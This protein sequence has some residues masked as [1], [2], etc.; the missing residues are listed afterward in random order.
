MKHKLAEA[1]RVKNIVSENFFGFYVK[2]EKQ[3]HHALEH[4][5][6]LLFQP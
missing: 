2:E 6:L 1:K 3:C 5:I 4:N